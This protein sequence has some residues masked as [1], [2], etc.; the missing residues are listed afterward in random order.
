MLNLA[1][2]PAHGAAL[3]SRFAE[4]RTIEH[5]TYANGF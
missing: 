4:L 1:N 5:E 2:D 3:Q